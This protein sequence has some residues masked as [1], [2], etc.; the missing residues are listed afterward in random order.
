MWQWNETSRMY[1]RF[2]APALG[3]WKRNI[4]EFNEGRYVILHCVD[5]YVRI[6]IVVNEISA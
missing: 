2:D 5:L 3:N 6:P 4:G 1:M